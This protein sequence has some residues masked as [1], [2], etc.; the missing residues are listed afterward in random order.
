MANEPHLRH[1]KKSKNSNEEEEKMGRRKH[2]K[3]LHN[4]SSYKFYFLYLLFFGISCTF[5]YQWY[6]TSYKVRTID[7]IGYG[8]GIHSN[9]YAVIIDAGST[10]SRILAFSFYRSRIDGSLKLESDI[11]IQIK[12]GLSSYADNPKAGAQTIVDLLQHAKDFIPQKSWSS[13]PFALRATAGLRL[14]PSEKAQNILKEVKK[15]V[16][17]SPFLSDEHSV[18][19]MD[20]K[21][22]GLFLWFTVNFYLDSLKSDTSHTIA[23]L[24]LG[25]GSVQLTFIPRK[26][27]RILKEAPGHLYKVSILHKPVETYSYSYLG[28]GLMSARMRVFLNENAS[29]ATNLISSCVNP[30]TEGKKWSHGGNTYSVSGITKQPS[31]Q[32]IEKCKKIIKSI[33]EEENVDKP[34]EIFELNISAFSYFFDRAAEAGI[35]DSEAG[36]TVTVKDFQIAADKYCQSSEATQPPFMCLDLTFMWS[37]FQYGFGFSPDTPVTLTNTVDGHEISWALGAAYKILESQPSS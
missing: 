33:I 3:P 15:V 36:G 7:Y 30:Q 23:T 22:E 29:N 14:L 28:L 19:I 17:D 18:S 31:P 16:E 10:G 32:R 11:F 13:T 21:D 20:G 35:V 9:E 4:R 27:D 37:L 2:V 1:Q 26:I 6:F 24:D 8:L 5:T 25:G 34:P 12:P